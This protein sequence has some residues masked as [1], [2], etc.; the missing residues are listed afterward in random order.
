M[1]Q[2]PDPSLV[3]AAAY[4]GERGHAAEAADVI[5]A[6]TREPGTMAYTA[7]GCSWAGCLPDGTY[8]TGSNHPDQYPHRPQREAEAG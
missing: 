7:D 8:L 6:A 1:T 4:L 2:Q 5:A 3:T